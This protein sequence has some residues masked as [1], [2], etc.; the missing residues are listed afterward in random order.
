MIPSR[1]FACLLALA[2]G[3]L[4]QRS[5][6][7]FPFFSAVRAQAV[8]TGEG[9]AVLEI[10]NAASVT[11]IG[12]DAEVSTTHGGV[13]VT[14]IAGAGPNQLTGYVHVAATHPEFNSFVGGL[15]ESNWTE[16]LFFDV[17]GERVDSGSVLLE[18]NFDGHISL[19]GE[20]AG[21]RATMILYGGE[22][23]EA[24]AQVGVA[25]SGSVNSSVAVIYTGELSLGLPVELQLL[26]S[27]GNNSFSPSISDANFQ[28]TAKITKVAFLTPQGEPDPSV[29][30]TSA[31]GIV[32]GVPEPSGG[33][34][35][36]V[37]LGWAGGRFRRLRPQ[38]RTGL[39]SQ[40]CLGHSFSA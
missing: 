16:T 12:A 26:L 25:Q 3:G 36:V 37:C 24:T 1:V 29:N 5:Y 14:A 32:Y 28:S 4:A 40:R 21:A 9:I 30:V 19:S 20:G 8:E 22:F 33:A 34:L 2:A 23:R 18:A 39:K 38:T 7:Q 6:G 15:T 31:S 13:T 11:L 10:D 27:A 17:R 35:A